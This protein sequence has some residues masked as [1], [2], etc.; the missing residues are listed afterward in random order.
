MISSIL[1][2][3]YDNVIEL[4]ANGKMRENLTRD[5]GIYIL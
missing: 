3:F 5:I 4:Y 2:K 1:N